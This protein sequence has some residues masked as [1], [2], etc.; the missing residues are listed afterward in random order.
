MRADLMRNRG[1]PHLVNDEAVGNDTVPE[2]EASWA[3]LREALVSHFK[4][5]WEKKE[6]L[7]PLTAA[8]CRP[9]YRL[10]PAIRRTGRHVVQDA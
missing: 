9:G 6:I 1:M 2:F 5:A 10:D 8:E 3:S 4:E 7:W